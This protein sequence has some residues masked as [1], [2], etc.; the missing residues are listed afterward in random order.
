LASRISRRIFLASEKK[1]LW[2]VFRPE[3]PENIVEM[4]KKFLGSYHVFRDMPGLFS[5]TWWCNQQKG[6]WGA[7]YIFDSEAD[8]QVYLQSE[9]WVKKVPEK[10][11]YKPE[12]IAILDLGPILYKRPI[13]NG[14]IS[15]LAGSN[16]LT[17]N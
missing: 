16:E 10:Y 15:W 3:K 8:L 1:G 5:K 2:V 11:G 12:I 4:R 17:D 9:L 7:L 14:E 6:E 13:T